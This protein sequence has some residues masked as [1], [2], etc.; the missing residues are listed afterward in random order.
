MRGWATILGGLIV[1]TTH[2][3]GLYAVFS[4]IDLAHENDGPGRW[5]AAGFSLACAIGAAGLAAFAFHDRRLERGMRTVGGW[6][7]VVA[8]I[9][10]VFQSAPILL[11]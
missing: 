6:G 4:W 11:S 1:W 3:F 7:G 5:I 2:M 9:A 8:L 10:I